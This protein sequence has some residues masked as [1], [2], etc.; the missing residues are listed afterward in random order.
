M[1]VGLVWVLKPA[2]GLLTDFVPLFGRTRRNYLILAGPAAASMSVVRP[3]LAAPR[4]SAWL[5]RFVGSARATVWSF[6][7]V[8]ADALLIDRGRGP[9]LIGR[10][11]AAQWASA[12]PAG[13]VAGV[14]GGWLSGGAREP[15]GFG[16][17]GLAATGT[18]LLA[19]FAVREPLRR[20][21]R[22]RSGRPAGRPG[23]GARP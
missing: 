20:G 22:P 23:A 1:G 5:R 10:F 14:A 15:L 17:C 4:R 2:F 11:Q 19:A 9:G 12:Y 18:M 16:L 3:G 21:L 6:A 13:I 8:V 7:D